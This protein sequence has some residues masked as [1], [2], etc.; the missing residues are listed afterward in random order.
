VTHA[1]A[2]KMN[3]PQEQE[4]TEENKEKRGASMMLTLK[5]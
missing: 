3:C 1:D 2:V 4:K 5:K